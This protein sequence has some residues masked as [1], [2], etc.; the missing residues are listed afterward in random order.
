[1]NTPGSTVPTLAAGDSVLPITV[2]KHLSSRTGDLPEPNGG[3][4]QTACV[5]LDIDG[6]GRLDIVTKPYT[7]DTPRV[8]VWLNQGTCNSRNS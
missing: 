1:M 6:D 5:I 8:D 2:W 7:W 4:Q 3:N